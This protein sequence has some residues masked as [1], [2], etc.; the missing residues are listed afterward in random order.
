MGADW[1]KILFKN[2]KF[3]KKYLNVIFLILF[4][5][6]IFFKSNKKAIIWH[7]IVAIP[8]PVIPMG[9][10]GPKPKINNGFKTI[11]KKKLNIRTFLKVF[12]SPSACNKEFSA[13][14]EIKIK[15]PDEYLQKLV[16]HSNLSYKDY[17]IYGNDI[18]QNGVLYSGKAWHNYFF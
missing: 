3:G 7:I 13:T 5:F 9:G 12:V 6:I 4:D 16:I 11:F 15:D 10:I 8:I 17:L 1:K 14:T 2:K 18:K